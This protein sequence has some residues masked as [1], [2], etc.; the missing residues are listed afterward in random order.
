[1]L[2]DYNELR[3]FGA[4]RRS[5]RAMRTCF[6]NANM[7]L[8]GEDGGAITPQTWVCRPSLFHLHCG[9]SASLALLRDGTEDTVAEAKTVAEPKEAGTAYIYIYI[10]IYIH[11]CLLLLH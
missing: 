6:R 8:H 7:L 4:E 11:I 1:M 10:Y 2:I 5:P 3:G 9:V